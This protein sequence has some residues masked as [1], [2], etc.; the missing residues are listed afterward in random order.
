MNPRVSRSSALA[1]KATGFPIAKVAAKLA[2]GYT[3][4]ELK[5]EITSGVMPASFEPTLDYVVTK[6]PRFSFEKFPDS[7]H[8]LTTQMKSVGEVMAIGGNFQESIQKALRGLELDLSG[9][10]PIVLDQEPQ[11]RDHHL[12]KE[13]SFPSAH[14]IQYVADAFRLN[15]SVEEIYQLT[16]I[17]PWFLEEIKDLI[18]TEHWI[19]NQKLEHLT[20][21]DWFQ[22]KQKGF[23]DLRLAILWDTNEEAV[24]LQRITH[25]IK[26]VFKRV[27]TCAAEFESCTDYL[28]ATYEIEGDVKPEIQQSNK[29]MVLGSGP[30]RI[31][32]GIEFDYCCVHAALAVREMGFESIMVNCNP[33][34]V[35]TDFDVANRLYF[36]SITY[37]DILNIV[38]FEKPCG[39]IIQ[40]GGQTPLKLAKQLEK[41]GVPIIGTPQKAIDRSENR[42]LFQ[43]VV[44]KL[45]L[46]QPHNKIVS[47]QA[48]AV[49]AADDIQYPLIVR[50]SYV[51]GGRAMEIIK[52]QEELLQYLNDTV[53]IS[54]DSPVLLDQY[55]TQAIEVDVD[56]L[57]DAQCV[58]IVAIMQH[59][60]QAGIHSGDSSCSIMPLNLE[61]HI[62]DEIIKNV[63]KL[64]LE[65]GVIGLMNIQFA[66]KKNEV[67]IIEVNP[68]ASRTIPF[69]SKALGVPVAKLGAQV[70]LGQSLR[71]F[72]LPKILKPVCHAVKGAVFSFEKFS[73]VDPILGPEMRSTGEVMGLGDSFDEAYLKTQ[74]AVN[75]NLPC[76]GKALISVCDSD[77]PD[78][79]ALAKRLIALDFELIA[80][81]GTAKVLRKA[82]FVVERINKVVEGRPNLVDLIVNK[83]IQL[84]VNTTEDR[85][86]IKDSYTIRRSAL[87]NRVLYTTTISGALAI[88]QAIQFGPE[89]HVRSLQSLQSLQSFNK[90]IQFNLNQ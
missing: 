17:D 63:E 37:E 44:E 25:H 40:Y 10:D 4:D 34:T 33:E 41:S 23:S 90:D 26:P 45:S 36:E 57:C 76:G 88:S 80:T 14:R 86:A 11:V 65:L 83:T 74:L 13:L 6:M 43:E 46:L 47:S 27:D 55:L 5:N 3:L 12:K 18:Q 20:Q 2:I 79:I 48:A 68:R 16:H 50:P 39:V 53:M 87:I 71:S 82:G 31:G 9:F 81:N 29:V 7:D 1:S 21:A 77:K 30:N 51:L 35:S 78:I 69:I 61:S 24:R 52:S 84:V 49:E 56:A 28:Y 60:E 85:Q 19:S 15:F 72:D 54:L 38:E 59:I 32:Q 64:A 67:Y 75:M 42:K 58:V 66:V 8:Q 70:M 73:M 22:L 62:Q 89:K